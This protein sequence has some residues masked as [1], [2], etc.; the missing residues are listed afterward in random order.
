MRIH[1]WCN[2]SSLAQHEQHLGAGG[3]A[4]A[5]E[6]SL[7]SALTSALCNSDQRYHRTNGEE[8]LK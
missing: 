7:F 4:A 6:V 5:D 2:I 3:F 1:F 8:Q